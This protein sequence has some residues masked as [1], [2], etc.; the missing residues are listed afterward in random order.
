MDKMQYDQLPLRPEQLR[1]IQ[2]ER[3]QMVL[4]RAAR[5]VAYYHDLFQSIDFSPAD[6]ADLKDLQRLPL[7]GRETLIE[8][9]PYGM[10]AVAPHDVVRIH[11]ALGPEGHPIVVAS[12]ANDIRHWTFLTARALMRCRVT[13]DDTVYI[14][15]D[16]NQSVNAFGMHYGAE[17]LGATVIPRS[18][19]RMREQMEVMRNYRVS[20]L[21]CTPSYARQL[22]HHIAETLFDPKS[23]F[24][25]SIFLVG[26]PWREAVRKEIAERLFVNVYGAYGLDEVFSPGI[27]S[28]E[29]EQPGFLVNEDHFLVEIVDSRSHDLTPEGEYGELVLTT[30]TKEALPLIRYRTGELASVQRITLEGGRVALRITPAGQRTDH[31]IYAGGAKFYPAQ[32]REL[33][34]SVS[35]APM[36]S[37]ILIASTDGSDRVEIRAE[38]TSQAFEGEMKALTLLKDRLE[39]E[40]YLK[41]GVPFHLRWMER[42]ALRDAPEVDD[43]RIEKI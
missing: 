11:T 39:S 12:T 40:L 4:N 37:Q 38:V 34:Q 28:E 41:F 21:V 7:T 1:Q 32:V 9:Q 30:L 17:A 19:I 25:R 33:M 31:L 26:E 35:E 24:L 3:L 15:L 23:L 2:L 8:R 6:L 20:V 42:D 13:R 29:A 10:L 16:Y 27:A 22:I 5:N 18:N 43:Q 36:V 14:G